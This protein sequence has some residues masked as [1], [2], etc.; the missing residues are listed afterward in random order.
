MYPPALI[1]TL[2]FN[3]NLRKH[4]NDRT[5]LHR[6]DSIIFSALNLTSS[7]DVNVNPIRISI[8]VETVSEYINT[9]KII[10]AS[11]RLK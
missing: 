4:M 8:S 11:K 6:G 2:R 3:A 1:R 10:H 5:I 9:V 7:A